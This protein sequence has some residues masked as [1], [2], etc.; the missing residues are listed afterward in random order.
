MNSNLKGLRLAEKALW[1]LA[2]GALQASALPILPFRLR[3]CFASGP[4]HML[5]SCV[6]HY[7]PFLAHSDSS[8][9][10]QSQACITLGLLLS[11]LACLG[12][13]REGG[14][15]P[16]GLPL[17]VGL[18]TCLVSPVIT[19]SLLPGW[20]VSPSRAGTGSPD[21]QHLARQG[22]WLIFTEWM[23]SGLQN[24]GSFRS[25][26]YLLCAR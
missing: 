14:Q 3:R 5:F 24:A 1:D 9:R 23:K 4:L 26:V 13:A 16:L 10:A 20:T 11:P 19:L 15:S 17:I 21:P 12:P 2:S 6:K 8:S 18:A 7:S 22:I 25:P